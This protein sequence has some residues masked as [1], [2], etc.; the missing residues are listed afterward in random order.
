MNSRSQQRPIS[1]S[2]LRLFA[3]AA[4]LA[5]AAPALAAPTPH[6]CAMASE[7]ASS[8]QKQEKLAAAKDRF[9]VCADAACPAEIREECGRRITEV[10]EAM[11]SIVFQVKDAAGN[12]V[13]AV[14]VAMDGAPLLDQVGPAAVPVDPGN[15]T[16]R[17]ETADPTQAVEKTFVVRDGEKNR[18]LAVVLGGAAPAAAATPAP[19][20]ESAPEHRRLDLS[21]QRL[22]AVVAGGVG[23]VGLGVGAAFGAMTFSQWNNA[24]SECTTACAPGSQAQNDKSNASTSATLSDVGF[25]AGGVFVAAAA[26]LWFTAPSEAPVQVVPAASPQGASLTL[27]GKF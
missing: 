9:L 4:T 25:I 21:G 17:F 19:A 12:D 5:W 8:L 18:Q 13:S 20:V 11:P 14:K 24:R 27:Q 2:A 22:I 15:H 23:L 10:T 26:V 6:E 3:A 7:D 16:F 1:P